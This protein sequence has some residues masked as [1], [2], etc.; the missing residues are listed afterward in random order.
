MP[1]P[2]SVSMSVPFIP[3]LCMMTVMTIMTSMTV[4]VAVHVSPQ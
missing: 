2:V 4:G 3:T 1:M